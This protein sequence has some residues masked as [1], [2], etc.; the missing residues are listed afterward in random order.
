M[1]VALAPNYTQRIYNWA[2]LK[3]AKAT[4]GFV[5]QYEEDAEKYTI[6]GYDG[7]EVH[8]CTIY[9]GAVPYTI[10]ETYSQEQNDTDKADFENGP[11]PVINQ[12]VSGNKYRNITGNGT[13]VVKPN[14]G[15]LTSIL[16]NNNNTNGT[17]TVY[18]S[19]QANGTVI[20]TLTIASPS[21][22]LGA[23]QQMPTILGP[24]DI[25]FNNGLTVVT[26]GSAQNNITVLFR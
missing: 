17:V 16:I 14:S 20:A 13:T 1:A 26:A 19:T 4:R 15:R 7:P 21:G 2:G 23:G 22:A 6:W 18:D 12:A 5:Y 25:I 9:K 3:A 10:A 8:M 24:L 11:K